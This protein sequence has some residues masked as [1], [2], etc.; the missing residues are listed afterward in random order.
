MTDKKAEKEEQNKEDDDDD[1]DL[2]KIMLM[3]MMMMTMIKEEFIYHRE[4]LCQE[5][6]GTG[7][8]QGVMACLQK[9]TCVKNVEKQ[10][11]VL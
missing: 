5:N 1:D 9:V 8:C 3:M 2:M 7:K 6:A 4:T 11:M 10:A